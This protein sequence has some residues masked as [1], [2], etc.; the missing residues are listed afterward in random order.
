MPWFDLRGVILVAL[1]CGLAALVCGLAAV[2][3]GLAAVAF[4]LAAVGGRRAAEVAQATPAKIDSNRRPAAVASRILPAYDPKARPV[5]N[6][7]ACG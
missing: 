6:L 4:G 2:A 3:C 7:G 5:M 1:V